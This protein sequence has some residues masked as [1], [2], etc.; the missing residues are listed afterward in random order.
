MKFEEHQK[1]FLLFL[2][3]ERGY[4]EETINTYNR[5]INRYY[6]FIK[7]AKINYLK[8][9]KDLILDFQAS[10]AKSMGPRTFSRILSTLRTFYKFLHTEGVIDDVVLNEVKS[11]PSPKYQKSIPTFLSIDQIFQ[12]LDKINTDS[13]LSDII[14]LRNQS[15]IMLFFTSGLRLE[16][17]KSIKLKD[18]D[19]SKKTIR[20][21]GK[22]SK[23]RLAN[24]D[25]DTKDL[26]IEYLTSL[27]KYPLVKTNFNNNLFV[28]EKNKNLSRY[29]IQYLVMKNL[30]TLTLNSYGPHVLRHSFATHLLNSGVGLS[31]IKSLLGHENLASTQIYTHVTLTKLQETMKKSHPRGEK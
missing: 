14:K 28:N 10:V 1:E 5:S 15:L 19:F 21:V 24:F 23:E 8:I 13:K 22:G 20:V 29:N 6:L 3:L 2:E 31:A 11:Y 16:E 25:S 30:K 7:K 12:V 27:E 9:D 18:I 17:L 26:M 4:S